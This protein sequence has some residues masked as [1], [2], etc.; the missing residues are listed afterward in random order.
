MSQEGVNSQGSSL[1]IRD[2]RVTCVNQIE[3]F[4]TEM[5]SV[6]GGLKGCTSSRDDS[7]L[8]FKK[9]DPRVAIPDMLFGGQHP[10]PDIAGGALTCTVASSD[11]RFLP[12]HAVA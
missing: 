5:A 9:S 6:T 7:W 2:L 4:G 10:W 11:H 3:P 12:G 8:V 1:D